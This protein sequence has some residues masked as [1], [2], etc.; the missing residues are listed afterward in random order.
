[1]T[2]KDNV[3]FLLQHDFVV[4][5]FDIRAHHRFFVIISLQVGNGTEKI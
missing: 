3:H 4:K 2:N 5:L 1:M